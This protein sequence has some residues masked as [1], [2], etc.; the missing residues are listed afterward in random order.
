MLSLNPSSSQEDRLE[1]TSSGTS[2]AADGGVRA[3]EEIRG[4]ESTGDPRE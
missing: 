4:P 1:E 2:C 3:R